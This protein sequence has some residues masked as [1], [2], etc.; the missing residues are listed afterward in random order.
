MTQPRFGSVGAVSP[1]EWASCAC[2]HA[3]VRVEAVDVPR[4]VSGSCRGVPGSGWCGASWCSAARRGRARDGS[5]TSSPGPAGRRAAR[6][7]QAVSTA[8][9]IRPW[10]AK[11]RAMVVM[12]D[13]W[14]RFPLFHSAAT[15][16][17]TVAA[18]RATANTGAGAFVQGRGGRAEQLDLAVEPRLRQH[19]EEPRRACRRH[20]VVGADDGGL[21]DGLE[22]GRLGLELQVDRLLGD[23]G[24]LGDGAH[25]G[26]DVAGVDEE[27]AGGIHDPSAGQLSRGRSRGR[28]VRP[29][30][31]RSRG[32][33]GSAVI[34]PPSKSVDA[35][36][37][38]VVLFYYSSTVSIGAASWHFPR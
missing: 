8:A 27:A 13:R 24:L 26:R 15:A 38:V 4:L 11:L 36:A 16:G 3:R 12:S 2:W 10:S 14:P 17:S 23:P 21:D 30:R 25:R 7:S 1:R 19:L 20:R 32:C 5:G 33:R 34:G 28:P 31:G 18:S 22:D 37:T 35:S 9:G 29:A 6:S